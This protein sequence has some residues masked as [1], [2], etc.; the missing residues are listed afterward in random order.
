M[1]LFHSE[2]LMASAKFPPIDDLVP[3]GLPIRAVEEMVA[4]EKGRATCRLRVRPHT[5]FVRNNRVAS[6]AALEYMA[7]AVAACLG[8]E[9]FLGG[10]RVRVGM[11][12]GVRK[13]ELFRPYIE[14]GTEL[15]IDVELL[16]GNDDVSTFRTHIHAGGEL[17][18]S[19]H[20]TLVHP[21]TPPSD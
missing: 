5:P 19:A 11:I 10:G 1:H 17:V 16:R 8:Y 18:S 21:E 3:H 2:S 6:A 12:V 9:A 7:Q 20:M 15:S 4:W 13:L 14:V